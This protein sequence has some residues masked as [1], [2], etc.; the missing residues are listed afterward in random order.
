MPLSQPTKILSI[1]IC[2][3]STIAKPSNGSKQ[4]T[5]CRG[6]AG[7]KKIL[8]INYLRNLSENPSQRAA[9]KRNRLLVTWWLLCP[10]SIMLSKYTGILLLFLCLREHLAP[11]CA[12]LRPSQ[13]RGCVA[14]KISILV[15]LVTLIFPWRA[16]VNR[17]AIELRPSKEGKQWVI[18]CVGGNYLV[19]RCS[20]VNAQSP[21]GRK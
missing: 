11:F 3:K 15:I 7:T 13:K 10:S 8:I 21:L 19:L 5:N 9:G 18:R 12:D 1:I 17:I 16:H 2:K 20:R 4:W 6:T 14:R